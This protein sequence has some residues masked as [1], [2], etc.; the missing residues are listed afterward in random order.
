MKKIYV[1]VL[2]LSFSAFAQIGIATTSPNALLDIRSS[3]QATPSNTDG[4]LIPKMDAFPA[5]N[6]TASQQGMIVYL[7]TAVGS[8]EVGFYYWDFP[9]L[10]WIAFLSK[11]TTDLSIINFE[12]FIFDTYQGAAGPT[13]GVSN[14]NQYSF[15]PVTSGTATASRVDGTAALYVAY[16]NGND[17]TGIHRLDTGTTA[18]GRAAVGSMDFT[19]RIKLKGKPVVFETRVRFPNLSTAGETFTAYIGLSDLLAPAAVLAA[20]NTIA[21]GVYFRYT[22]AGI[23]GTCRSSTVLNTDTVLAPALTANTWYKFKAEI[24]AAG[25][26]VNFYINDVQIG[27][28][29]TTNIPS[30]AMKF[31][32]LMEKS[33]G[34]TS[35]TMDIDFIAWKMVR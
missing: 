1:F 7:N 21:N 35:R 29:I 32:F 18:T 20:T 27:S 2:F 19:N 13:T 10:S 33:V 9:T 8:K 15:S 17:Y 23:L 6:P 4:L 25:T 22:T 31:V 28:S 30:G 5:I 16:G 14:D 26:S 11:N 34:I 24:N 12:D 3:N